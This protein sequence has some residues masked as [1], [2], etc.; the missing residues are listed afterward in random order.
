MKYLTKSFLELQLT[1]PFNW[2]SDQLNLEK[3]SLQKFSKYLNIF[4]KIK[5][6]TKFILES[7][8]TD[9]LHL[10]IDKNYRKNT[11]FHSTT[12][13]YKTEERE[14]AT[15]VNYVSFSSK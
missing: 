10:V 13:T 11:V 14:N 7:Q 2:S 15:S 5:D 3:N 9:T 6:L 1:C 4:L 8:F 12:Q